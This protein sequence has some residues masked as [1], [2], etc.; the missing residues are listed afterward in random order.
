MEIDS[1]FSEN[2][3]SVNCRIIIHR[4][5]KRIYQNIRERMILKILGTGVFNKDTVSNSASVQNLRD[6][7]METAVFVR[8]LII[9]DIVT[10]IE[11]GE[12][13]EN[14]RHVTNK[15]NRTS[16]IEVKYSNRFALSQESE[17]S[18]LNEVD[19]T[20]ESPYEL[21]A[22]ELNLDTESRK[23]EASGDA[24]HSK[25]RLYQ[26]FTLHAD[27]D[28]LVD[29]E[30]SHYVKL[31][32]YGGNFLSLDFA[33]NRENPK[34]YIVYKDDLETPHSLA[35]SG[36][37]RNVK[38]FEIVHDHDFHISNKPG[39]ISTS[40]TQSYTLVDS[41]SKGS[42]GIS[43]NGREGAD[44]YKNIDSMYVP[45]PKS[46]EKFRLS[47]F[48]EISV[49]PNPNRKSHYNIGDDRIMSFRDQ[50]ERYFGHSSS[51]LVEKS[52]DD[53]K[54]HSKN[55]SEI[56]EH[57][58]SSIRMVESQSK[59]RNHNRAIF[60]NQNIH[61]QSK[62]DADQKNF[63]PSISVNVDGEVLDLKFSSSSRE[64]VE[65]L[66]RNQQDLRKELE[67]LGVQDF[68]LSFYNGDSGARD[69][70]VVWDTEVDF[71]EIALSETDQYSNVMA[72]DSGID[73]RI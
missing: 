55:L 10:P 27:T 16:N 8:F 71:D 69:E 63:N 21:M 70:G 30:N 52:V 1:D 24:L 15:K 28:A 53:L 7:E 67:K 33:T 14:F 65:L 40:S 44:V 12:K 59:E 25:Y 68:D 23:Y 20:L 11:N 18:N 6:F 42:E 49:V 26:A 48:D 64:V 47:P 60:M 38:R 62:L 54:W 3:F 31:E 50:L 5:N 2:I 51:D 19:L 43:T 41:V 22:V 58:D 72:M 17:Q 4:I 57:Q 45:E 13:P 35:T 56:N 39:Q 37:T 34:H 32:G 29:F 9:D 36:E 66:S 46:S 73:K 61:N